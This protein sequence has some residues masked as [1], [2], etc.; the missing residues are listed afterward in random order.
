PWLASLATAVALLSPGLVDI[1]WTM[2]SAGIRLAGELRIT[3]PTS[4]F[5]FVDT[6]VFGMSSFAM[7]VY[8]VTRCISEPEELLLQWLSLASLACGIT[9]PLMFP[10]C[11]VV[12]GGFVLLTICSSRYPQFGLPKYRLVSLA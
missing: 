6:M 7:L 12:V 5:L 4:K 3:P 2:M 10:S 8:V 9:Y 11:A 1:G